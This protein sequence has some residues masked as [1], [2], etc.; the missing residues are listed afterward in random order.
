[1]QSGDLTLKGGDWIIYAGVNKGGLFSYVF[2]FKFEEVKKMKKKKGKAKYMKIKIRAEN[3]QTVKVV[4]NDGNSEVEPDEM[5]PQDLD[6][7]QLEKMYQGLGKYK[8]VGVV[9]HSHSSPG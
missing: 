7:D 9:L 1:L 6:P 2:N 5:A 4:G 3:G 8:Y